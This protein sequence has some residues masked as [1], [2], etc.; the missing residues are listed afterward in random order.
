MTVSRADSGLLS[1]RLLHGIRFMLGD[2][3]GMR[4]A[5][6]AALPAW[7]EAVPGCGFVLGCHAFALEE[8][9]DPEGA[10][11]VGRRAVALEPGDVWGGH[12]VTHA[13]E[14]GGRAREGLAW[15][16]R[17]EPRLPGVGNFARHLFWHRALF[18]LRLGEG[19]AALDL[20]DRRIREEPTEDVRDVMNAASLLWRLEAQGVPTGGW[21]WQE[22]ADLAERRIGDHAWA[23]ADLHYLLSLAAA[24]RL[25]AV[26]A[27]L[28]SI[29]ARALHGSDTQALVHAE[30]GLAAARAVAAAALEG[31]P[32]EAARLLEPLQGHLQRLGGSHTQRDLLRQMLRPAAAASGREAVAD[33]SLATPG[34]PLRLREG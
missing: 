5:A 27:M 32:G 9:G 23:F 12:A 19:D 8:T 17:I 16:S 24:G 20:Y 11:R 10:E 26:Q 30:V 28:A 33:R 29:R 2:S 18:H 3:L 7:G 31:E 1:F 13:M 6:K 15:L 25:G 21:R 22:L 14:V 34:P 4:L